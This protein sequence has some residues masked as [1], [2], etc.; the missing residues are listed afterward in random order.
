MGGIDGIMNTMTKVQ[1]IVTNVQQMAP[2]VKLL[3]G[4]FGKSKTTG[5]SD[6]RPYRNRRRNGKRR[7]SSGTRRPRR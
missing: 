1:K 7:R 6:S 3:M 2:M 5:A 4:S